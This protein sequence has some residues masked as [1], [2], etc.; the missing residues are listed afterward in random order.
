AQEGVVAHPFGQLLVEPR[1]ALRTV[2]V[3]A[4]RA[5]RGGELVLPV[6]ALRAVRDAEA[7]LDAEA[8]V[9][10]DLLPGQLVG[11][12]VE[13]APALRVGNE[14]GDG[15]WALGHLRQRLAHRHVLPVARRGATDLL[16]GVEA[17]DLGERLVR[18][19]PGRARLAL[20]VRS[21]RRAAR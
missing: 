8:G 14:A 15:H 19:S 7:V 10:V 4:R 3:G 11:A 16:V 21:A 6:H 9:P 12:K 2:V 20:L 17:I 13:A 5:D 18:V 1:A